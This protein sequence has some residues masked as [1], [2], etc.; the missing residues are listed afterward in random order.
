MSA[1]AQPWLISKYV[2]S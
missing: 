1:I 2:S